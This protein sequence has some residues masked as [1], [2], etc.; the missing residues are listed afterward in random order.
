MG[1]ASSKCSL[2][3]PPSANVLGFVCAAF[4]QC[5]WICWCRLQPVRSAL[6]T[7]PSAS[8]L[9]FVGPTFSQCAWLCGRRLQLGFVGASF[10]QCTWLCWCRLQPVR[11][12]LLA[13]PS[14]S[15]LSFVG[16]TLA[17]ALGFVSPAF[18]QVRS[19]LLL[20]PQL[21]HSALLALPPTNALGFVGATFS[22]HSALLGHF[23]FHSC[24]DINNFIFS[25]KDEDCGAERYY[26][27][28][29]YSLACK[30]ICF[31][32]VHRRRCT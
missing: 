29:K 19:A 18:K 23:F 27:W 6:L 13:L 11:S 25:E 32:Q 9:S 8:A 17:S 30:N 10:S 28:F 14:A 7:S 12:A 3:A 4:S 15:A 21:V 31:M 5:A 22:M 24:V 16:P 1:S 26:S 2:L 20:P